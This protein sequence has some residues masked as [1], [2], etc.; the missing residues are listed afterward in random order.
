MPNNVIQLTGAQLQAHL[1]LWNTAVLAADMHDLPPQPSKEKVQALKALLHSDVNTDEAWWRMCG[2]RMPTEVKT[3]LAMRQRMKPS[4]QRKRELARLLTL[5][6]QNGAALQSDGTKFDDVARRLTAF[7][8]LLSAADVRGLH[9]GDSVCDTQARLLPHFTFDWALSASVAAWL[10]TPAHVV[11]VAAVGSVTP[12]PALWSAPTVVS[13]QTDT[14]MPLCEGVNKYGVLVSDGHEARIVSV[15]AQ[16]GHLVTVEVTLP[17]QP[18]QLPLWVTR[19]RKQWTIGYDTMV[20]APAGPWCVH[21]ELPPKGALT[22]LGG[23]LVW[24]S[25]DV[26]CAFD[27]DTGEVV[28]DGVQQLLVDHAFLEVGAQDR[29]VFANGKC[30]FALPDWYNDSIVA[31][32]KCCHDMVDVFSARGDWWR[33]CLPNLEA[34]VVGLDTG[35]AMRVID[36]CVY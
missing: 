35:R 5:W 10:H 26:L 21:A 23:V 4:V 24:R 12:L 6:M 36:V 13:I 27:V 32:N 2:F 11:N 1:G 25:D 30:L 3:H 14:P 31:V 16:H 9:P 22:K 29:T 34:T 33:V 19:H 28:R 18:H 7:T 17:P 15:H 20:G 8:T